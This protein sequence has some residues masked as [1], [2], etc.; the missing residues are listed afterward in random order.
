MKGDTVT[1]S[2]AIGFLTAAVCFGLTPP[3]DASVVATWNAVALNCTQGPPTPPN[4][5]GPAG[6]L[7]VALVHAAMHDAAQAVEGR[8]ES[9]RYSDPTRLGKGTSEAAAAAA[10]Y[11][12]LVGLYQAAA[13][14]LTNV[15]DPAATYAGDAGLHDAAHDHFIDLCR[16]D[17]R[18]FD[19]FLDRDRSQLRCSESF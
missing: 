4:R 15:E 2:V 11:G 17:A 5:P 9:Y 1:K 3:V 19:R 18:T 10:A 7:D 12:V 8:F 16:I 6:L 14:C 13:P